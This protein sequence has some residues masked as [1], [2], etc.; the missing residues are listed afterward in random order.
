MTSF[1]T[2]TSNI[3]LPEY[4]YRGACAA[5]SNVGT[6]PAVL[7]H[8]DLV[9]DVS[10]DLGEVFLGHGAEG[11]VAHAAGAGQHHPGPGVVGLDVVHQVVTGDAL[12]VLSGTEDSSAQG[13]ALVGNG[14]KVI[15]HDLLKIHLNLLH[16]SEIRN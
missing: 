11:A 4:S 16:L 10:S 15:K 2:P 1:F 12:D 7:V 5:K 13:S 8:G 6:L 9:G 3:A 14:V